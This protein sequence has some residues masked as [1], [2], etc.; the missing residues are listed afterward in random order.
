MKVKIEDTG[1][2]CPV[3]GKRTAI[4]AGFSFVYLRRLRDH[5]NCYFVCLVKVMRIFL[6]LLPFICAVYVQPTGERIRLEQLPHI[7]ETAMAGAPEA[8]AGTG[9]AMDVHISLTTPVLSFSFS[10]KIADKLLAAGAI[11]GGVTL[12]VLVSQQPERVADAVQSVLQAPGLAVQSIMPGSILV[13]LKCNKIKSFLLFIERFETGIVKKQLVEQ[14][15]KLG[16]K[17]EIEVTLVNSRE[18][19]Q[20]IDQIR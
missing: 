8:E 16:S 2:M 3:T 13:T 14:F 7:W 10:V 1:F 20:E 4:T 5:G 19:Y 11:V 15:K 6:F 18:W 12:A 17:G 9:E